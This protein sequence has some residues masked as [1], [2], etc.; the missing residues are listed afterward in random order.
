[1]GSKEEQILTT[2]KKNTVGKNSSNFTLLSLTLQ[3]VIARDME[4]PQ[5]KF[6]AEFNTYKI[7]KPDDLI[8]CLFDVEETPRTVGHANQTGM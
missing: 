2:E 6:P 1:M 5:G 8:F 3:G 7:V 4:N